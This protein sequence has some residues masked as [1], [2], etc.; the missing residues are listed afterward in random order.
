MST[1]VGGGE[2]ALLSPNTDVALLSE[3][4][5]INSFVKLPTD[6]EVGT[7]SRRGLVEASVASPLECLQVVNDWLDFFRPDVFL[8]MFS[9]NCV[10]RYANDPILVTFFPEKPQENVESGGAFLYCFS[11]YICDYMP[12][13]VGGIPIAALILRATVAM[14]RC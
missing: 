11:D 6:L 10:A 4:G 12:P 5:D 7:W 2:E 14:C 8:L 9:R 13:V 1:G 3:V